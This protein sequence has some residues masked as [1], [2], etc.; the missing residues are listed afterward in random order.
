MDFSLSA[1]SRMHLRVHYRKY[2][3]E[4]LLFAGCKAVVA[5]PRPREHSLIRMRL[6]LNVGL[7]GVAVLIFP[8]SV[9]ECGGRIL[10]HE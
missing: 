10:G 8:E 5:S 7:T 6:Q 4:L 3:K 9:P 1:C 2:S